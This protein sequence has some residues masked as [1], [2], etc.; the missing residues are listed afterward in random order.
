MDDSR[1]LATGI[2]GATLV[3]LPEAGHL[4]NLERPDAFNA[5]V[6]TWLGSLPAA[7]A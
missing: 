2:A 3:V 5:A 4:S 6:L 1:A 7:L